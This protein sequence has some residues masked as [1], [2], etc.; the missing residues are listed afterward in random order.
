MARTVRKS[1]VKEVP[2]SEIKGDPSRF[3]REAEMP[4]SIGRALE[5]L[6]SVVYHLTYADNAASIARDGLH[7]AAALLKEAGVA[8]SEANAF[9]R[10][11]I[12]LPGGAVL[13]NQRPM[14]PNALSRCLDSP[15]TPEDWYALVNSRVFFWLDQDRL[16]RH[17]TVGRASPQI[18]YAVS[19]AR[20][21]ERYAAFVE[22]SPFNSGS[23]LR[24]AAGRGRRTFVPLAD[25]TQRG[26]KSEALPG[27]AP[28][29][30]SHQPAELTVRCS[31]PDFLSLVIDASHIAPT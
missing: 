11:A 15:L 7:P 28:R 22:L 16:S 27:A 10:A 26:W 8:E 1:G 9:R 24:R 29:P 25:W 31:I 20:L 2:L 19:T 13:R 12:T 3:L 4:R 30:P 6:P 17:R 18:C 21:L 5:R 14:P 23:A